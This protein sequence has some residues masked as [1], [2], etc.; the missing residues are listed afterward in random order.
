MV[1]I[2]NH[3]SRPR[4]CNARKSTASDLVSSAKKVKKM[5][6]KA[7][8]LELLEGIKQNGGNI[9]RNYGEY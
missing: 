5:I 1:C 8:F 6:A 4:S 2:M 7:A 3:A 9:L